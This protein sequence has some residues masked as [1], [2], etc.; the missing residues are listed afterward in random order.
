MN[1]PKWLKNIKQFFTL[2]LYLKQ[3]LWSKEFL[4]VAA[5]V[6]N[7]ATFLNACFLG[8]NGYR[9]VGLQKFNFIVPDFTGAFFNSAPDLAHDKKSVQN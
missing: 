7:L 6:V 5:C 4:R 1:S 3:V 8:G 9:F 2:F